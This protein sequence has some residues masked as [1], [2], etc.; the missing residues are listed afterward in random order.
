MDIQ[1]TW[2]YIGI[3]TGALGLFIIWF[4]RR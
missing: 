1:P 3:G 2:T 4:S